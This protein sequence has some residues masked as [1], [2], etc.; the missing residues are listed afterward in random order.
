[1]EAAAH[2]DPVALEILNRAGRELAACVLAVA[3]RLGIANDPFPVAH[4]GGAFH[5]GEQLIGPM[6][7]SIRREAP[8][9]EL[10][11]PFHTPV[12]GAA[13]MAIRAATMPRP[14]RG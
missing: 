12:E 8:R 13:M 3:H 1:M 5:A 6:R 2:G 4:V 7:E 11:A 10:I 14:S 9:A